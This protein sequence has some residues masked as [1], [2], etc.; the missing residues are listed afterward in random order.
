MNLK[1]KKLNKALKNSVK[2]GAA[3]AAMEGITSTYSTPFALALGANNTE[4]GILNSVPNLFIT[5]TQPFAG[6]YIEKRRKKHIVLRLGLI[7]RF[8]W[9]LIFLIPIFFFKEGLWLFMV[10]L[11]ISQILLSFVNTAWSSWIGDLV[12]EKIRGSF[13]GKRS[14]IQSFFSFFTTLIAGWIL[15]L[16]KNLF[17]FSIIFF[18]AFVF[19]LTSY[20]YLTKIPE[21]NY[22]K[23]RKKL[24]VL[25]FLKRLKRYTNFRPFTVHMSLLNFAVNLASP[26]FTVYMLSI[27][28]INYEWYAIVIAT[29]IIVRIFM[30]RYWGKLSDKFGDRNIMALC[31]IL[32][33]FYPFFWLFIISPYQLILISIFAGIAWSGFDL[34]SFNYLL[35]VTPPEERPLYIANYKMMVG[36][37]L[38]LGPLVGGIL[39]QN[40]SNF[41]W[42][43]NL[44]VLF[45]ISFLLRGIVTAYGLP[46]IKEVRAKYDLP[47]KDVFLKAFAVYPVRGITHELVYIERKIK[48]D[49]K[50]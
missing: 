42:L 23:E 7:Q 5:L 35:D 40:I 50:H 15:G 30:Q 11:I 47:V 34:T 6:K 14:M 49:L 3:F 12:P 38:F 18:L 27:M 24:N 46:K 4:I 21:I 44:Q 37:S 33:V 48:K 20:F 26:F 8:I 17:G 31:N 16:S 36:F 9:F 2:D 25:D 22:K 45:L 29:E 13:F 41:L 32:I 10:L 43:N 1:N 39:S 19:G 28:K